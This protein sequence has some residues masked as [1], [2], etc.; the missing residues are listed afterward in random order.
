VPTGANL[1]RY[2]TPFIAVKLVDTGWNETRGMAV[3][4]PSVCS[5]YVENS[6][7]N[8]SDFRNG[9]FRTGDIFT[10]NDDGTYN[11]VGRRKHLIKSG[12]ENI[13]RC[14]P[15]ALPRSI[16]ERSFGRPSKSGRSTKQIE[17]ETPEP[18]AATLLGRRS[19]SFDIPAGP[20]RM[21]KTRIISCTV[22]SNK[23]IIYFR[24]TD[25]A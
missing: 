6:E 13:Y 3:R 18:T 11:F 16:R 14:D 12:E 23:Y 4:C 25:V 8:A 22:K 17:S 20:E 21:K 5:G 9:W 2:E 24:V 1:S 7:T 19:I 10:R 15:D